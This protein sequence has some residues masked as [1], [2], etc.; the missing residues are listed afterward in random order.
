MACCESIESFRHGLYYIAELVYIAK[1][2]KPMLPIII[3]SSSFKY[4]FVCLVVT[5]NNLFVW[6]GDQQLFIFLG[7]SNKYLKSFFWPVPFW[8]IESLVYW[9]LRILGNVVFLNKWSTLFWFYHRMSKM[10]I[11]VFFIKVIQVLF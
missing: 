7:W 4:I 2:A 3:A 6:Q 10:T 1:L 11:F 5:S 8:F 9:Y